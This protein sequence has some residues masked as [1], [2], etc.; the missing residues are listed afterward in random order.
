MSRRQ[1]CFAVTF[2]I[3]WLIDAQI[4]GDSRLNYDPQHGAVNAPVA[5]WGP[6]L[7][8]DGVTPRKSDGLV[9]KR[10]DLR[11]DGTHPSDS[12]RKKV[13]DLLTNFFHT[14]AYARGWYLA[15]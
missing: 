2:S 5:L 9:W 13:A 1:A 11:E 7:W 8:G 14:D 15:K 4:K 3:R 10:E 12:G 6:Y